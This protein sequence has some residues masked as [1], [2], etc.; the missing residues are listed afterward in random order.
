[1]KVIKYEVDRSILTVGFAESNF[2][3]YNQLAN[4]TML[5]KQ[6]QNI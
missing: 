2:I 4:D 1:L 5:T 3:V 6:L